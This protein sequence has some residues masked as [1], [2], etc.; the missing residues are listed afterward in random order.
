M[1]FI[2]IWVNSMSWTWGGKEKGKS[3]SHFGQ[4]LAQAG[5]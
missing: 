1:T 2:S 4:A 5:Q 3:L